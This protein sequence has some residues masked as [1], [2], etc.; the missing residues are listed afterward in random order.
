M[1][2][3]GQILSVA[4]LARA[5]GAAGGGRA[6]ARGRAW[7]AHRGEAPVYVVD[8]ERVAPNE[9]GGEWGGGGGR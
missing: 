5:R 3:G 2:A 4:P 7:A 9:P 8:L 6:L 1:T